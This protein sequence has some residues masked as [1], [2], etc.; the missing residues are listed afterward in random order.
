MGG[1]MHSQVYDYQSGQ[2]NFDIRFPA[3]EAL[4][5]LFQNAPDHGERV[6]TIGTDTLAQP[7]IEVASIADISIDA[8]SLDII[9]EGRLCIFNLWQRDGATL[10][11]V[12]EGRF[13]RRATIAPA[14]PV[15][16][17]TASATGPLLLFDGDSVMHNMPGTRIFLEQM[18][19]HKFRY[20]VGYMNATGGDSAQ[21]VYFGAPE[22]TARIERDNTV[23]LV[24]PIGANQT[25]DDDSF[26]EIT[27]FMEQ[28]FNQYLTAG[29]IVVAVPTLLDGMGIT[30]QDAKKT[31][32]ADWVTAFASG[33]TVSFEGVDHSVEPHA[34]FHAVDIDAFDRETMKSDVSHPNALGAEFL[35]AQLA[36]ILAPLVSGT[37]YDIEGVENLLLG[38]ESFQGAQIASSAGITG[39]KP[40]DWD[41]T[42][43][44]G[45]GTWQGT[46]DALGV[47]QITVSEAPDDGTC[48]L[49]LPAVAVNAI[50]G[51]ILSYVA[52]IEI[53]GGAEGLKS[54]GLSAQGQSPMTLDPDWAAVAGSYHLRTVD[55]PYATAQADQ[56]FQIH[57]R[58]AAGAS[59]TVK[60]PR[61]TAFFSG[62]TAS[63]LKISGSPSTATEIG[64]T[65]AFVPTVTGGQTPYGFDLAGGHLPKGL[66]L[67]PATGAIGGTPT[68]V[69]LSEGIALRVTDANGEDAVLP[70]F[71]IDVVEASAPENPSSPAWDSAI[72]TAAPFQLAYSSNDTTVS[73]T[74]AINGMRHTRGADILTGKRYFEVSLGPQV[75]GVGISTD[76]VTALLGGSFGVDRAFWS[77]G[78]LFYTGGNSNMGGAFAEGDIIQIAVDVDA[79]RIW[80]RRNGS[81]DWNNT[82]GADP[83]VGS[84]GFDI[85]GLNGGLY[86]YA[87]LQND[88]SA[89]VSLIG[90]VAGFTYAAPPGFDPIG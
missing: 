58:V 64:A 12:A 26:T 55:L 46:F 88:A 74:T 41:V 85:S 67:N 47:F 42:R 22:V 68:E 6:L 43:T 89:E 82:A 76:A 48:M 17:F 27:G 87:G 72:N 31:A 16:P 19:G 36:G 79:D 13:V 86:A 53:V 34:G 4:Q 7:L 30:T 51:D 9:P 50:A 62:N 73:A 37:V 33:G 40:S 18:L 20:P 45:S 60:F 65:Y 1:A 66:S 90:D 84:G 59:L 35:S 78:F 63:V 80:M 32:L 70:Y 23:V 15:A 11:L 61:A 21:K 2:E 71:A 49:S 28:I 3:G 25:P 8:A 52:Q 77:G 44:E 69:S 57:L 14:L 75:L 39:V 5:L 54:V 38:A 83:A 29:A 56:T 10:D 81:G 24:G